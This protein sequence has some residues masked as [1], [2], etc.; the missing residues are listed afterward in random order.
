[1]KGQIREKDL[2]GRNDDVV[3]GIVSVKE[4][5]KVEEPL[6]RRTFGRNLV[7]QD[8]NLRGRGTR[9]PSHRKIKLK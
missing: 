4:E 2:T 1:M 3:R 5:S 6:K 9:Y 7:G 8:S